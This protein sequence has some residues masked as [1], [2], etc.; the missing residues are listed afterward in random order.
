LPLVLANFWQLSSQLGQS[1]VEQGLYLVP[2]DDADTLPDMAGSPPSEGRRT[3][4][5]L[6][7]DAPD[8]NQIPDFYM[9]FDADDGTIYESPPGT[10]LTIVVTYLDEGTDTFCIQYDAH[11]GGPFSDGRFR[12]TES[13]TKTGSG[14]WRTHTFILDDVFFAN[15]DNGADFRI[16]DRGNGAE[17]IR[18]VTVH[19]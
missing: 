18:R 1:N 3:G 8:D 14:E 4:N 6:A 2:N 11:S 9:Q 5:G 10:H 13:V 7:Q 16:D 19:P 15:R 12:D 17:V